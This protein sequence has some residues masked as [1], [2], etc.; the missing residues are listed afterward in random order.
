MDNNQWVYIGDGIY[1]FYDGYRITLITGAPDAP[2][3]TIVFEDVVFNQF[4][5][6][7]ND[8]WPIW[9]KKVTE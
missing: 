8:F 1:G 5:F 3:N 2:E 7:A 4:L 9:G 6:W